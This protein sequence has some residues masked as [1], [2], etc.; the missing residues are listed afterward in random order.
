MSGAISEFTDLIYSRLL[1]SFCGAPHRNLSMTGFIEASI[2]K[3]SEYDAGWFLT[4]IKTG[5]VSESD[6]F[7]L[8]P[9]SSAKE[10]I[11]WEGSR[12][13]DPRPITLWIEPIITIG[14]L[15]R[16]R[17]E[18]G[19][20]VEYL[21]AQ[22]KTWAFDLVCY[23][24]SSAEEKIVCE[25]KKNDGEIDNLL[26]YMNHYCGKPPQS[27]EPENPKERNAYRKVQGIRRSWPEVFWALGPQG[28]GQ[29]FSIQ[30][31]G[32]S[33]CFSLNS[34]SEQTLKYV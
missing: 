33:P 19:W 28:R 26:I 9:R 32:P 5:I 1:P 14:A 17:M 10:Q 20:P 13:Q 31:D 16:L 11:F 18:F 7:F 29:V 12:N 6:G 4:A 2:K 23:R 15:A 27:E 24:D 21:G 30:R 34:E 25:V 22:S 3:L 8:A